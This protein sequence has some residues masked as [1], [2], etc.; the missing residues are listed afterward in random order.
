VS[1]SKKGRTLHR[2]TTRF[3]CR[4]VPKRK[5][6]RIWIAKSVARVYCKAL[7]GG[8]TQANIQREIE[9]RC[10]IKVEETVTSGQALLQ[11]A[12]AEML[13][14]I[15]ALKESLNLFGIVTTALSGIIL[16]FGVIRF[17]GP[18]RLVATPARTAA[19]LAQL[20]VE[21]LILRVTRRVQESEKAYRDIVFAA[22]QEAGQLVFKN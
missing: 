12:S 19:R 18:L 4:W 16:V 21:A 14:D 22:R 13:A 7:Q 17:A 15:G 10:A 5:H 2:P 8:E 1:G 6:Q 20:E 9:Q 11:K 3:L